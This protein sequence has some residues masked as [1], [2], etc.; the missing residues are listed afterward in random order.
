[1]QFPGVQKLREEI[2]K[3]TAEIAL[4]ERKYDLNKAAEL[5]Y[6]K[7][8]ELKKQLEKME[9]EAKGSENSLLRDKVTEEEIAKIICRWTGIPVAKLME[10]E[11]QKLLHLDEILHSRVIGQDE[12][13]RKV[14]DAVIRSRAGILRPQQTYRLVYVYRSYR[15]R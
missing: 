2:D 8:P 14:S 3:T 12:A 4:A 6:G 7:L 1:M 13:V 11:R 10:G 15:R 5:K 9:E